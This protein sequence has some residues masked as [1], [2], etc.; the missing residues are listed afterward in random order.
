MVLKDITTR[1][2]YREVDMQ[3]LDVHPKLDKVLIWHDA[4]GSQT[5]TSKVHGVPPRSGAWTVMQSR[6]KIPFRA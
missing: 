6:Q 1:N 3:D 2:N 4:S 5:A